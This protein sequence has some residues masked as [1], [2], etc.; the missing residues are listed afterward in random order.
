MSSRE[1][2]DTLVPA[3][4]DIVA[5]H[6]ESNGDGD[7]APKPEQEEVA[8]ADLVPFRELHAYGVSPK[9]YIPPLTATMLA[10]FS[11]QLKLRKRQNDD[12]FTVTGTRARVAD[13]ELNSVE[14]EETRPSAPSTAV[15]GAPAITISISGANKVRT[16][17]KR[18]VRRAS[19]ELDPT[20]E[21]HPAERPL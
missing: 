2:L 1:T 16:P 5:S 6:G 12:S 18:V 10:G 3:S 8:L 17:P 15:I 9:L 13:V 21:L 20:L 19:R 7:G 4:A 11:D 14:I